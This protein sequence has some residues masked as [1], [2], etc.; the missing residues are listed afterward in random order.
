MNSLEKLLNIDVTWFDFLQT[1]LILVLTYFLL[2][3]LV[4]LMK[5]FNFLG[6]YQD[7]FEK[8]IKSLL[9]IFE[10]L[11]IL[12]VIIYF[13]LINPVINGIIV[14]VLSIVGSH[15]IKN[16][17]IGKMLQWD[18]AFTIGKSIGVDNSRG[19]ISKMNRTGLYLKTGNGANF[20]TF[21]QLYNKGFTIFSGEEAGG[22][23]QLV[24]SPETADEKIN[25]KTLLTDELANAPYL[26]WYYKSEILPSEEGENEFFAKVFVKEE[27]HLKEL[28]QLIKGW[29]FNCKIIK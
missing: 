11:A 15:F 7:F 13:V 24:L 16:Y 10:P 1:D 29:G 2:R 6:V 3:G 23:H 8:G 27:E 20:I 28:L 12:V 19:V 17:L 18:K 4:R 25:Y 9:L 22:Y 14:L 21:N 5:S 26:D